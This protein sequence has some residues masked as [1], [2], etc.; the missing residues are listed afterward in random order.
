[1]A[2]QPLQHLGAVASK[3]EFQRFITCASSCYWTT[4]PLGHTIILGTLMH[5]LSALVLWLPYLG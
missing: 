3:L 5:L 2:G 4:S 1:M